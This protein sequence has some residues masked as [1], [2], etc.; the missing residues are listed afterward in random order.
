MITFDL[1]WD[2]WQ[3]SS[4]VDN[5]DAVWVFI[6]F[7]VDNRDWQH[8]TL[9]TITTEHT[10][11]SGTTITSTS[12]GKGV[13]IIE[14][15]N[16]TGL[17]NAVDISLR[18]NYG[19]DN[20]ADDAE[21]DVKVLGIEMVYIPDASFYVGDADCDQSKC[22]YKYGT[23]GPFQITSE[24]AINMGQTA[25]CLWAKDNG[26]I[27]TATL[28]AAFP[29]GYQ[30]FYCMKY[31][32]SQRQYAEFLN[33]LTSTQATS[34]YPGQ[35]DY[36]H[37]IE[38]QSGV[39]GC[40]ANDNDTL[41]EFNDGEWIACNYLSWVDGAA[42]ADWAGL[43]PMTELEFEKIC[44]GNQAV[45]DDE[46]AW[47]DT[48]ITLGAVISNSAQAGEVSYT[49][50]VIYGGVTGG[51]LRC[52]ALT[53]ADDSREEAGASYYGVM[54]MSGNLWERTVTVG[55]SDGRSFGGSHGDGSLATN[56]N[57]NETYWP[58]AD[59]SGAGFRGGNWLGDESHLRVSD[60]GDAANTNADR[61]GHCGFRPVR[62]S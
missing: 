18:W 58:G 42:Y 37:Y 27:E 36:R 57:A 33:T 45:V 35:T 43:R 60:R 32:I 52:G 28:P 53:D 59:A 61:S 29:K 10:S 11:L 6:K 25:D 3:T 8:A 30:A 46:Y 24:D 21:V 62:T 22:F 13:F 41:N 17:L 40:D 12:G 14:G 26:Y 48:S 34:R 39:Y 15:G 2:N 50:N 54:E 1:T 23:T 19:L 20:V 4:A 49:A 44:R 16:G 31:E 56:G 5:W 47:G 7:K 38:V 55:N 51:P 9:S